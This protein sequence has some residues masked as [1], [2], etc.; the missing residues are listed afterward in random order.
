MQTF[1]FNNTTYEH[2]IIGMMYAG[3]LMT[4]SLNYDHSMSINIENARKI[5]SQA[6][7]VVECKDRVVF[8][9]PV[10]IVTGD[11]KYP[12][13]E[14]SKIAVDV[15]TLANTA[16]IIDNFKFL[17]DTILHPDFN[18]GMKVLKGKLSNFL[19]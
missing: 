6:E 13:H 1:T 12:L 9:V 14:V 3:Y 4:E 11:A 8:V 10:R 19:S 5:Y 17:D 7:I 15:N 2:E 18:Y 16:T